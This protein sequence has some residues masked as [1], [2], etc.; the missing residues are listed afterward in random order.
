MSAS[1]AVVYNS[2]ANVEQKAN[3]TRVGSQ[4]QPTHGWTFRAPGPNKILQ[5]SD[6]YRDNKF[7]KEIL[8]K[9]DSDQKRENEGNVWCALCRK[10]LLSG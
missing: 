3:E 6:Y 10:M 9:F 2:R 1:A 8:P 5:T 7:I 4:D